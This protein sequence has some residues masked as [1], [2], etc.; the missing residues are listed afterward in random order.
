MLGRFVVLSS[1]LPELVE[2]LG[3]LGLSK[4]VDTSVL[5]S[6][7]VSERE[8]VIAFLNEHSSLLQIGAIEQKWK[9]RLPLPGTQ[10][11]YVE[12]SLNKSLKE[13][14]TLIKQAGCFAKIRLGG[15]EASSFPD[16]P[17]VLEFLRTCASLDLAFKATAG[18]HHP[19]PA[20]R[21]V[22]NDD[23]APIGPMHGFV[24]VLLATAL[25]QREIANKTLVLELLDERD[26]TAFV[27]GD[28][29]IRFRDQLI[30]LVELE[31]ARAQFHSIGSC[32]FDV[33]LHDLQHA[34]WLTP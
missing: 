29:G 32:S 28:D 5:S 8:Q 1:Q 18:L 7:W 24:N 16:S 22:L 4:P 30:T 17:A 2:Q 15:L 6:D 23:N 33:P 3:S 27:V 10:P 31:S 11:V 21:P 12:T 9:E 14:L 34:G 20:S 13:R 19:F 26:S 25:I